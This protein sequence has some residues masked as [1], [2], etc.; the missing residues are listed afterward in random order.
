LHRDF[1]F[2]AHHHHHASY[3]YGYWSAFDSGDY[4]RTSVAYPVYVGPRCLHSVQ[5]VIVPREGGGQQR[6]RI[7][8]C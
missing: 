5:T 3:P 4:A 8:R 2:R 1:P 7:T 6:V